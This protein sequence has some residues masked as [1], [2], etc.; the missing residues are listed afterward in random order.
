M[1]NNFKK[2]KYQQATLINKPVQQDFNMQEL[3]DITRNHI[4]GNEI[5]YK[6]FRD[7]KKEFPIGYRICMDAITNGIVKEKEVLL[8][9]LKNINQVKN[10]YIPRFDRLAGT[11][12]SNGIGTSGKKVESELFD[13]L[14][15]VDNDLIKN[16]IPGTK[17]KS[18]AKDPL[19]FKTYQARVSVKQSIARGAGIAETYVSMIADEYT[20]NYNTKFGTSFQTY[21]SK[22]REK[23]VV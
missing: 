7:T 4:F 21:H 5:S 6:N 17:G 11:R 2:F 22:K 14:V 1:K 13:K 10:I 16:S 23:K 9:L 8:S 3:I 19:V 18:T 12:K 20:K 15:S